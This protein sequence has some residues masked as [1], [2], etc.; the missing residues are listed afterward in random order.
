MILLLREAELV[1]LKPEGC[2]Q[3]LALDTVCALS[4]YVSLSLF[5]CYLGTRERCLL[6]EQKHYLPVLCS[7]ELISRHVMHCLAGIYC[8]GINLRSVLG[9]SELIAIGHAIQGGVPHGV[10]HFDRAGI[11]LAV[12]ESHVDPVPNTG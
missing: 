1:G 8:S 6:R 2:F 12:L 4:L 5:H 7:G 10:Q 11:N 3:S 9:Q